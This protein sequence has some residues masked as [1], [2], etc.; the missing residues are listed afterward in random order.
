MTDHTILA[1]VPR[2]RWLGGADKSSSCGGSNGA[3]TVWCMLVARSSKQRGGG[4]GVRVFRRA[5]KA[6]A[7]LKTAQDCFGSD[8]QSRR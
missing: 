5:W 1:M 6:D 7:R 4:G 8:A 2:R 3:G